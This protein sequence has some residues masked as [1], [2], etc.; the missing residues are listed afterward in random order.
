M[1]TRHMLTL[2]GVLAAS[3]CGSSK[4]PWARKMPNAERIVWPTKCGIPADRVSASDGQGDYAYTSYEGQLNAEPPA[5]LTIACDLSW[6]RDKDRLA[7][8]RVSIGR[9]EPPLA[10]ADIEPLLV[11]ALSELRPADQVVARRLATGALQSELSGGLE[12]EGGFSRERR[13]WQ[14]SVLAK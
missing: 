3:A 11:L 4:S 14:I 6:N 12:I 13:R 9:F 5:T 10:A 8:M 2:V 7:H 1:R